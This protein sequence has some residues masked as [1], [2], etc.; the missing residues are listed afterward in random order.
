MKMFT[1]IELNEITLEACPRNI[2]ELLNQEV[3]KKKL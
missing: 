3:R 2:R 1:E